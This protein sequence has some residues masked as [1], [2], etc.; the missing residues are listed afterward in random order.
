[1][2]MEQAVGKGIFA[3]IAGGITW[4]VGGWDTLML[5]VC[6][7]M[8]I[9]YVSGMIAAGLEG[10]INS[11]VGL[12]GI[13]KKVAILLAITAAALVDRLVI[14][15]QDIARNAVCLFYIGNEGV[16]IIENIAKSGVP[17]PSF[18]TKTF[19]RLKEKNDEDKT[20]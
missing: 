15:G 17:I 12:K 14:P 2:E 9:D 1:M 8:V 5:V 10:E 16:S 4:L 18:L 20:E 7:M 19:E 3:A 6:I 11:K 13:F